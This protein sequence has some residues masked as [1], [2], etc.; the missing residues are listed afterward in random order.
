M[1]RFTDETGS[2]WD[3]VVGHESWGTLY[4]LFVPAGPPAER[5]IRQAL[6]RSA[7]YEQAQQELDGLDAQ[8]L[9]ALFT[10]SQLRDD[11]WETP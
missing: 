9:H 5:P 8:S 4:A 7:G 3:V 6:L 11:T 2:V 1:R 10:A